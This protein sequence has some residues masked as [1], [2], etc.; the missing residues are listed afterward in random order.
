MEEKII[1]LPT[2]SEFPIIW[3]PI[4]IPVRVAGGRERVSGK[5]SGSS[6]HFSSSNTQYLYSATTNTL[7]RVEGGGKGGSAEARRENIELLNW[8][9]FMLLF[10]ILVSMLNEGWLGR[11]VESN[12]AA[13]MLMGERARRR[14]GWN[15]KREKKFFFISE[16]GC[17]CFCYF[18][19]L[20]AMF[21]VYTVRVIHTFCASPNRIPP[22]P[23]RF[24]IFNI[25]NP[26]LFCSAECEAGRCG[27]RV[28]RREIAV[29]RHREGWQRKAESAL[30]DMMRWIILFSCFSFSLLFLLY[31]C[32]L[33][34]L[35][36]ELVMLWCFVCFGW[37]FF[38]LCFSASFV[39]V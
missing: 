26:I 19:A 16:K 18:L 13:L 11:S 33:P 10:S 32:P 37:G 28:G 17:W 35:M 12:W 14:R 20:A 5:E 36:L 27:A 3:K 25:T 30:V 4:S 39:I 22:P 23:R 21:S 38:R 2:F 1:L 24:A 6:K 29:H 9:G 15:E 8:K 34:Q 7:Q 31:C